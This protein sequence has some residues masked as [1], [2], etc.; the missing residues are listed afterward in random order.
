MGPAG[1]PPGEP[2][3]FAAGRIWRP[4]IA[5]HYPLSDYPDTPKRHARFSLC[6]SK[7]NRYHRCGFGTVAHALPTTDWAG[8]K[9]T[10]IGPRRRTALLG[11]DPGI[12]RDGSEGRTMS[13]QVICPNGHLLTVPDSS[14]GRMGLCPVCKAPV[15][16]PLLDTRPITE[17]AVV[18]VLGESPRAVPAQTASAGKDPG[19]GEPNT[20]RT[21]PIRCNLCNRELGE[22]ASKCPFCHAPLGD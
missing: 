7:R 21:H 18:G 5:R 9:G 12:R 8:S 16:V 1:R 19:E 17:N 3:T 22:K 15:K 14:A 11:G 4:V 13:I 2:A 20:G 10:G 6:G